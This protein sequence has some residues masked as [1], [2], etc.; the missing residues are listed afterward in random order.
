MWKGSVDGGGYGKIYYDG[1]LD[2]A[3]RVAWILFHRKEIPE[4]MYICHHCD[5]P[6]CV[7]P[8]HLFLGTPKDNQQDC[9]AKGRGNKGKKLTSDIA[10]EIKRMDGNNK[11]IAKRFNIKPHTVWKIKT[12]RLWKHV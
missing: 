1:K 8:G 5:T 6:G 12:G 11:E 2:K 10:A 4:G 3:N 7:N 9:L